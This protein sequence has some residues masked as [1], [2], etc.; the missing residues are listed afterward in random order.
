MEGFTLLLFGLA[1]LKTIAAATLR[2]TINT[3]QPINDGQIIVSAGEVFALGFF[4]P[5]NSKGRYLGIWYYKIPIQTVVWIANRDN[6]LTDSSGVLKLNETGLLVLLNHN[7]SVI[8]SSSTTRSAHYPIGKLLNSGNFIVQDGNNN[9]EPKDLLWQSFDYPVDTFLPQQKLG[10]NLITGLNRY[11]SSW[12]TSDDPSR[13]K[14]S[15]QIDTAGYPQFVIREGT[16]KRFRFGSWNGIQF[17]GAPQVKQNS[18]FRFIF[19]SNEEEI[20]VKYDLINKSVLHRLVL[21]TDG[22]LTGISWSYE[23]N[24]WRE[25]ARVPV[26]DCDYYEKCGAHAKCNINNFPPCNCLEGFVHSRQYTNGGCVRRTSLSCYGDGFLKF[27]GLKLPDTE[28]SWFDRSISLEDCRILC[29]KNCSCTAYAALD[30]SKEPTGC[31][32]WFNDLIDIKEF[33]ESDQDI[34]I[35]MAGTE[36]EAIQSMQSH[37]SNIRK[38]K[39]IIISCV[40]SI[41]ILLLCLTFIIHRQWRTRQK[42]RK[43]KSDL[44]EDASVT[45]EHGN[46]DVVELPMFDLSIIR[47]ATNNFTLENKLGE[48]GFGSV[49]KCSNFRILPEKESNMATFFA[50]EKKSVLLDWPRRLHIVNGIARG[51]LYL[52]EDSR[53]RIVHRDLKAG[54]VLLDCEMNPKISDF[55]LARSF[56]GNETEANT[57]HVVGTYGYMPP[58]YIIDGAYSTKSDVFSFGVLILEIVSGKKNRGFGHQ[59][60]L[61]AHAWRLFT[62]GKCTEIV[63]ATIRDSLN[64]SA[65]VRLIHVGLL[66][67][68]LCPD[69]RPSMSSVVLMLSSES[70]LPQPKL[71]GLFT[72][73]NLVG[74]S[75][76]S[77]SYQQYSNNDMTVSI[78]SAR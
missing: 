21:A 2:D 13:G 76:S 78:M 12:N 22:F 67:V 36:V 53:H 56:G 24:V 5:S 75:S 44:E 60:N 39:T 52:H 35:R 33:T 14:Y 71:P 37:K 45:N 73:R 30:I 4:S 50:D 43:M 9:N 65:A 8:W 19:V 40:L 63:Y 18:I 66:C 1:V 54:N 29:M 42:G 69:D 57:K 38:Q 3:L 20:Y 10:R 34:Y 41:G 25:F 68:Q 7:K 70:T 64:L 62:E 32:V 61:L 58:E 31:L 11:L 59:D 47:S 77:V 27:S 74:D 72:T 48:G 23:E 51:L 49:Y 28:R 55:G 16:V 46:E 15:H 26:D 6:P 17:S